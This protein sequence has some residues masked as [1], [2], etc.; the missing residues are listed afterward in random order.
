MVTVNP[1]QVGKKRQAGTRNARLPFSAWWFLLPVL[2]PLAAVFFSL[3]QTTDVWP[4]LLE[5]VLPRVT[6]NTLWLVIGVALLTGVLGVVLGGLVALTEFPGRRW[7]EWSLLLPLAAPGYVLAFVYIG[8]FDYSGSVQSF[9]RDIGITF[10]LPEIRSR[11]GVILVL[12]LTLYPYV[13]LMARQAFRSQGARAM[14]AAQSLGYSRRGAFLHAALP[15]ARPWIAGGIGLVVMETL[16]DFGTVAAFNYDTFTTAIYKTWFALFSFDGAMQL[17]AMLSAV[18]LVVLLVEQELRR[19]RRF[20]ASGHAVNVS[21]VRLSSRHGLLASAFCTL[22][23]FAA[24][25]LPLVQLLAWSFE[26]LAT[27]L[28]AGY[29]N[30]LLHSLLLASGAA[31]LVVTLAILFAYRLRGVESFAARA[32]A[33]V[34]TLGYGL[35]GPVLAVGFFAA[36][37]AA[38]NALAGTWQWLANEPASIALQGTVWVLFAAYLARFFAVGFTPVESAFGRIRQN[39]DEVARN[40]GATRWRVLRAVHMPLLRG[41][42]VTAAVLV[43]VDVLKEMPITLMLRPFGWETLAVR[44]FELTSEGEYARAALPSI[45]ILAAGLL[46]VIILVRGSDHAARN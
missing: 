3:T 23:L 12:G 7:F 9:M 22:V 39:I 43:F 31:L 25:A 36:M 24:F 44:V 33:R 45:A 14:E 21:R 1:L 41:G 17:S 32:V 46:P 34:A 8:I 2:V 4:H 5:Q 26:V 10:G 35:P 37:A 38:S 11:G 29:F 20:S 16:A 30:Y 40:L 18:V 15:L 42:V 6:L 27:E 28:S 13:Y 19:R